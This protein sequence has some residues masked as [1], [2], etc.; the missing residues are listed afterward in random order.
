MGYIFQKIA[1]GE[2]EANKRTKDKAELQAMPTRT[3]LDETIVPILLQGL[4]VLAKERWVR[5]LI[6]KLLSV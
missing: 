5:F 6:L 2:V 3:Y 4:G 1:A